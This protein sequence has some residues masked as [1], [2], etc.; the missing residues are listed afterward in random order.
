MSALDLA[1]PPDLLNEKSIV[2]MFHAF[3][4][5]SGTHHGARAMAV[6]GYVAS[7]KEWQAF[8]L[9]WQRALSDF[10]ISDFFHMNKFEGARNGRGAPPYNSW[11]AELKEKRF[12]TLVSLI[13]H[14]ARMSV[15]VVMDT[16]TFA[17]CVSQ[18]LSSRFGGMYGIASV[19]CALE[20]ARTVV[21]K[22]AAALVHYTFE[23]GRRAGY[24]KM[25][26]D[27]VRG[28]PLFRVHGVAFLH[29][30]DATPLQAADILAYCLY[31]HRAELA[32][33]KKQAAT[34]RLRQLDKLPH[35]WLIVNELN[36]TSLQ[37]QLAVKR[38]TRP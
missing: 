33:L 35:R 22:Q 25:A 30:R 12:E 3:L 21:D 18:T 4:D 37:H 38:Q 16:S 27:E 28:H 34:S 31:K 13:N 24:L 10:G 17:E 14:Y 19:A 11:S 36:L 2:A 7:L 6:A 23:S 15:G 5:E 32:G 8:N 9:E 26:F 20:V 1:F 29:K